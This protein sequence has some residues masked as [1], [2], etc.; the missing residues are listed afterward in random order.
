M[1]CTVERG[2]MGS[3]K[4]YRFPHLL[5]RSHRGIYRK[6][7]LRSRRPSL[8]PTGCTTSENSASSLGLSFLNCKPRRLDQMILYLTQ[9]QCSV[10]PQLCELNCYRVLYFKIHAISSCYNC[11]KLKKRYFNCSTRVN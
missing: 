9:T 5:G 11:I 4:W 7:A 6:R 2:G 1:P 10:I 3:G 8:P